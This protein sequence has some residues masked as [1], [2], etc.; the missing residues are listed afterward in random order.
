MAA[1]QQYG[2]A[3]ANLLA[4][5][6]RNG[7]LAAAD[8]TKLLHVAVFNLSTFLQCDMNG[9]ILTINAERRGD[10]NYY[11]YDTAQAGAAWQFTKDSAFVSYAP[12]GANPVA[13][14]TGTFQFA[15]V[16]TTDANGWTRVYQSNGKR[17]WTKRLT[18]N[19]GWPAATA[20][21]N[22]FT[23]N[24]PT[25]MAN[26][27]AVRF[28]FGFFASTWARVMTLAP[29]ATTASTT[30]VMNGTLAAGPGNWNTINPVVVF[31]LQCVEI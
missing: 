6:F 30:I 14:S 9:T 7:L 16:P 10:G 31:D 21:A 19:S 18:V 12:A 8:F 29:D 13:F 25:G 26:L 3:A 24:L 5:T 22:M 23:S 11:R 1:I 2:K 27:G 20:W 28:S 4:S 15:E 17:K